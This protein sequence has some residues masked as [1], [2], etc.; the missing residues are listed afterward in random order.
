[1]LIAAY[2]EHFIKGLQGDDGRYIMLAA[3][4]KHFAG[5]DGPE[6]NPSRLG[7][8]A[9]ITRQ[10]LHDTYL[11]AFQSAV[12]RG[13]ARG[14]MCSYNALNVSAILAAAYA[15]CC[16]GFCTPTR[17]MQQCVVCAIAALAGRY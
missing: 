16:S 2:A 11:P 9:V 8:D 12:Q 17:L 4:P 10:D 7:F 1:V 13:R 14:L 6:N 15:F 5:Y 3:T